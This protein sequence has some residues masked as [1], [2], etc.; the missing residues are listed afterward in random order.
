MGCLF[1][2]AL[3]RPTSAEGE[4]DRG[5]STAAPA[6]MLVLP[7]GSPGLTRYG[8]IAL[9]PDGSALFTILDRKSDLSSDGQLCSSAADEVTRAMVVP[10]RRRA[11]AILA[12]EAVARGLPS[13][14]RPGIVT[15]C[16]DYRH[17]QDRS[18]SRK[19]TDAMK[20]SCFGHWMYM[21]TSKLVVGTPVAL[22]TRDLQGAA[23]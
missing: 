14:C 7:V 2:L 22:T 3:A 16:H 6:D 4:M 20:E 18:V 19:C 23:R 15:P 8:C 11:A 1:N 12:G 21:P 10:K 17:L 9:R 5:P 13:Y